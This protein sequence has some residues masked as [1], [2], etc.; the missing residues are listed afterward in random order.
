MSFHTQGKRF[1]A[2]QNQPG[3]LRRD[4]SAVS[5]VI[6]CLVCSMISFSPTSK[7]AVKSL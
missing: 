3:D 1:Y 5:F 2:A 4:V 7:P 6:L